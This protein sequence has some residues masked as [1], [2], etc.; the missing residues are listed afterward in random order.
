M[1][2]RTSA[3]RHDIRQEYLPL[4][5]D[6]VVGR[7]MKDGKDSVGDVIDF[8]DDYYLTR[9]DW[10]SLVELGLGSMDE[11]Q[12][13]IDSQ[14]KAAFTRVYNQRS[15]PLPFMKASEVVATKKT[16]KEK[17]DIEDAIDESDEDEVAG[18]DEKEGKGDD[19]GEED[20]KKDKYISLPKKSKA[21]GTDGS[22]KKPAKKGKGKQKA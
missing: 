19:E 16:P 11:S 3:N 14:T 1:R 15:H 18:E 6:K 12:V 13:K 9:D 7:L 10:D 2:L 17:P 5:W 22:G 21:S 4:V 20:L 8:M